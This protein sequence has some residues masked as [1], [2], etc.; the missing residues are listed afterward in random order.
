MGFDTPGLLVVF[1]ALMLAIFSLLG[2]FGSA[3]PH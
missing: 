1:A 3:A 2:L